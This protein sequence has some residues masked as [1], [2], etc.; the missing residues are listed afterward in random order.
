MM[1]GAA[2]TVIGAAKEAEE[3]ATKL[4]K[5]LARHHNVAEVYDKVEG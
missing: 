1:D 5:T 4:E 2:N 3:A